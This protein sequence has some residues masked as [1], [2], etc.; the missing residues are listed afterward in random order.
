MID[1]EN[2]IKSYSL[3][4][5]TLGRGHAL[6]DP[7]G[8]VWVNAPHLLHARSFGLTLHIGWSERERVGPSPA[9]CGRLCGR[10]VLHDERLESHTTRRT[11]GEIT[12]SAFFAWRGI[13]GLVPAEKKLNKTKSRSSCTAH[14]NWTIVVTTGASVC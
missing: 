5:S 7:G 12:S 2:T 3:S 11:C 8:P 14:I 6:V 9:A 10:H 1:H 4:P 13:V